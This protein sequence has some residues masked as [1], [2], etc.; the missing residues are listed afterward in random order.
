MQAQQ[1]AAQQQQQQQQQQAAAAAVQQQQQQA[2]AQAQAQAVQQKPL[3]AVAHT[4][5]EGGLMDPAF[6][7]ALGQVS[8][9]SWQLTCKCA[10]ALLPA[11]WRL[12]AAWCQW[13]RQR[14]WPHAPA[15]SPSVC[16]PHPALPPFFFL[17]VPR[18]P[19]QPQV[20]FLP[21]GHYQQ[22]SITLEDQQRRMELFN[23]AVDSYIA[24]GCWQMAAAGAAGWW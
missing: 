17:P 2:A 20:D 16:L 8:I 1:Q 13:Q 9:A 24:G 19:P 4:L 15:T 22:D 5:L 7:H 3:R 18:F 10:G 12:P 6:Y 14:R 21:D 23:A 11:P